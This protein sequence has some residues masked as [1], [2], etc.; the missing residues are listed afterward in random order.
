MAKNEHLHTVPGFQGKRRSPRSYTHAVTVHSDPDWDTL[1]TL[2]ATIARAREN[3]AAEWD[4]KV[5]VAS[6]VPGVTPM[7]PGSRFTWTESDIAEAQRKLEELQS[8]EA[9]MDA[10]EASARARFIAG[11]HH[12]ASWHQSEVHAHKAAHTLRGRGAW[13]VVAVAAVVRL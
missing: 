3:A 10:A 7:L 13:Q 5:R 12:V 1:H 11:V 4:Y 6:A 8:R 2:P 9:A